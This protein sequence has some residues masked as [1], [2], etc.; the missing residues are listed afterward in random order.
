MGFSLGKIIDLG[1]A[2]NSVI[3]MDNSSLGAHS[4]ITVW[5]VWGFLKT[6]AINYSWEQWHSE[7]CSTLEHWILL[8]DVGLIG[9]EIL[10]K[11]EIQRESRCEIR[12]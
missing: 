4:P 12:W 2:V 3:S 6:L 7:N 9:K 1:N 5:G 11:W 8:Q 10:I